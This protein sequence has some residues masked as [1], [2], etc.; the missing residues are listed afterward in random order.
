MLTRLE[1]RS[2]SRE[3]LDRHFSLDDN[4]TQYH[5]TLQEYSKA[6]GMLTSLRRLPLFLSPN[7]A[8]LLAHVSNSKH[9]VDCEVRDMGPVKQNP[10]R[11]LPASLQSLRVSFAR[12]YQLPPL[13]YL[14][15]LTSFSYLGG[16]EL[17]Y[18]AHVLQ[19]E[20]VL[21]KTLLMRPG[22]STWCLVLCCCYT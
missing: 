2:G 12:R 9:L 19:A 20:D 22:C 15:A 16:P 3:P 8:V 11:N 13:T 21:P 5:H 10:L 1:L 17:V 7:A 4:G 18:K 6:V 14:T